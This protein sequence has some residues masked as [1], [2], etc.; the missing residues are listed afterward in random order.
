MGPCQ[1]G[2][3][4]AKSTNESEG[5]VNMVTTDIQTDMVLV[6]SEQTAMIY[7]PVERSTSPTGYCTCPTLSTSLR[8]TG[9]YRRRSNND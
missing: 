9:S 7:A 3:E 2:V 5:S 8:I 6:Q 1:R 4:N